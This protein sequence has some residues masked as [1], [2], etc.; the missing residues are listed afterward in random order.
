M[1]WLG[2]MNFTAAN[3][4]TG[5]YFLY[6]CLVIFYIHRPE[7]AMALQTTRGPHAVIFVLFIKRKT[8]HQNV[9]KVLFTFDFVSNDSVRQS[10]QFLPVLPSTLCRKKEP[11]RELKSSGSQ[12]TVCK[13]YIYFTLYYASAVF[14]LVD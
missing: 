3:W 14:N 9:S 5:S 7:T 4:T 10:L 1:F 2:P 6:S 12:Q 13:V 8:T 11:H